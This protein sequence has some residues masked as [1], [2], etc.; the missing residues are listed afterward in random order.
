MEKIEMI[1]KTDRATPTPEG[2]CI[3]LTPATASGFDKI[4]IA[5]GHKPTPFTYGKTYRITIEEV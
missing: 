5:H 1:V 3:E 4:T 2:L